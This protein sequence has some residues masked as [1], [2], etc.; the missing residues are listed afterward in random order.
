MTNNQNDRFADNI[1]AE[2][3]RWDVLRRL[4]WKPADADVTKY[5][6][7]GI[8]IDSYYFVP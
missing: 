2:W 4:P 6:F 5:V 1:Y 3:E 8:F 7:S